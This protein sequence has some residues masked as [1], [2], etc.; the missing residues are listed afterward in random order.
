MQFLYSKHFIYLIC[1]LTFFVLFGSI[2]HLLPSFLEKNNKSEELR[3]LE[4]GSS[5][6]DGENEQIIVNIYYNEKNNN[7]SVIE[8]TTTDDDAIAYAIYNKSYQR[9]GWDYLAISAYEK[10]DS[11]YNDSIKAYAM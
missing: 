9:T 10:N 11:K 5:Y 1:S 8:T 3:K 2:A 4:E 6:K 7:Y